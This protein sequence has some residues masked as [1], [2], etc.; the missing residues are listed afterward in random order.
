MG[1]SPPGSVLI[2]HDPEASLASLKEPNSRKFLMFLPRSSSFK[3]GSSEFLKPRSGRSA[4]KDISK[5]MSFRSDDMFSTHDISSAAL[6]RQSSATT[7]FRRS[8]A[9]LSTLLAP[10]AESSLKSQSTPAAQTSP[11]PSTFLPQKRL[12]YNLVKNQHAELGYLNFQCLSMTDAIKRASDMAKPILCVHADFPGDIHAGREIFSHPL[13]VEACESLF[14]SV[15][16]KEAEIERRIQPQSRLSGKTL[17]RLLDR[18]ANEVTSIISDKLTRAGLLEKMIET[19][20]FCEQPVP[21]YLSILLEE[22]RCFSEVGVGVKRRTT[23]RRCAFAVDNAA[24]AEVEFAGLDGVIATRTG[25]ID[26][27]SAVE[28]TFDSK[29]LSYGCLVRFAL[30]QSIC[31]VIY[32]CN[33]EERIAAQVEVERVNGSTRFQSYMGMIQ[34]DCDPKHA[35]R[36]TPLRFVPLTDLQATRVNRLVHIGKFNEA[37]HLLSPRQ[38]L[39]LM[40]AM[41]MA[42]KKSFHQVIDVPILPAWISVSE[43]KLPEIAIESLKE[44]QQEFD[45]SNGDEMEHVIIEM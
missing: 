45:E 3:L 30:K 19:L 26:R 5:T 38:G 10:L 14:I 6:F 17:V 27:T 36:M 35:L 44:P 41:R 1:N 32:F 34:P 15:Y 2:G 13:I 7:Q 39:I 42:M 40:S 29:R 9:E 33:N 37:T 8:N 25:W 20:E 4:M 12:S 16:P 11:S 18:S 23:D 31:T 21:T 28:V 22:E 24:V 43:N